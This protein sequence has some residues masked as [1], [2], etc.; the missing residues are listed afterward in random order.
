MATLRKVNGADYLEIKG[1]A[2]VP[3]PM[4]HLAS[5]LRSPYKFG[6][7]FQHQWDYACFRGLSC[8]VTTLNLIVHVRSVLN[9]TLGLRIDFLK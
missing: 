1:A 6:I 8:R 3:F 5:E 9:E 7:L 4:E 2:S